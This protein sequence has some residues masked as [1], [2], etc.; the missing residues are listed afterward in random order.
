MKMNF[1]R[2][3]TPLI[4]VAMLGSAPFMTFAQSAQNN[5]NTVNAKEMAQDWNTPP[6]GTEQ[7][8]QG[9]RDG[10]QAAK[11]DTVAKRKI[12]A[13]ASHLYVHP[14]VK[15]TE[16]VNQYRQAFQ[17]GYQAALEHAKS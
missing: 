2:I 11:L 9:Y 1:T 12:D 8:Q 15:G 3:A 4:A 6:A 14:P 16:A 13:K 10:V 5:G 7:A 17:A